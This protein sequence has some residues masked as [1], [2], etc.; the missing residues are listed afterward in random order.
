MI[1]PVDMFLQSTLVG[2][3]EQ[4]YEN[5]RPEEEHN[6]DADG[7]GNLAVLWTA[8]QKPDQEH[9]HT[10][11]HNP[12]EHILSRTEQKKRISVFLLCSRAFPSGQVKGMEYFTGGKMAQQ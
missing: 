2:K 4:Q 8:G 3:T 1:Q 5:Q 11:K 10:E 6:H 12:D 7:M 9:D